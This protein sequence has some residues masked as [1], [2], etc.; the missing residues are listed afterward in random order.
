MFG[1]HAMEEIPSIWKHSFGTKACSS[2]NPYSARW[3]APPARPLSLLLSSFSCGQT[4]DFTKQTHSSVSA[5]CICDQT[6]PFAAALKSECAVELLR[7]GVCAV[8]LRGSLLTL[9]NF[10]ILMVQKTAQDRKTV[11]SVSCHLK[12]KLPVAM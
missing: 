10:T 9:P 5:M 12:E 11:E 8:I 3:T 2:V 4:F 1:A 6:R 7:S